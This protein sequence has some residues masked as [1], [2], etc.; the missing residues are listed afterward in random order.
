MFFK[1]TDFQETPI[2]R[3]PRDWSVT[4]L[5]NICEKVRA[6]GTPLTSKKE[7]WNGDLPFVKIEDITL[8]SKYLTSTKSFISKEGLSNSN[9]WLVPENSL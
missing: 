6:G 9:A 5:Q 7:Y 1:E 8:A 3:F 4:R 2:G